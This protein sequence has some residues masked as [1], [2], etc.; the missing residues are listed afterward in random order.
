[1]I[2][3][4]SIMKSNLSLPLSHCG[5]VGA[6]MSMERGVRLALH[7]NRSRIHSQQPQYYD[8]LLLRRLDIVQ[9][10]KFDLTGLS[11]SL[12]Y[13]SNDCDVAWVGFVKGNSTFDAGLFTPA[14]L[15][16]VSLPRMSCLRTVPHK[17]SHP[18][19]AGER[20]RV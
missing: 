8:W 16:N 18:V 2:S 10:R 15:N 3:L 11:Q 14:P 6:L 19:T 9:Y 20:L 1:M 17:K 4:C 5:L 12:F 13:L 7:G